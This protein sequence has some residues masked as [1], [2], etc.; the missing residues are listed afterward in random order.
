MHQNKIIILTAPS[1]AGKTSITHYLLRE[2]PQLAFSISVATRK[3]REN[4]VEGKDYYFMTE[5]EF[6]NR[7]KNN[8][9]VEWEMVYEGKIYGTLKSELERIWKNNQVPV[10][11]IDVKGAIHVQEQYPGTLSIFIDPPSVDELRRRLSSRGTETEESLQTR[12]NKAS[13]EISFKHHF[14]KIILNDNLEKA[15]TQAK[16]AVQQFLES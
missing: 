10:L 1:G 12:I 16:E 3:R 6:H 8:E 14:S 4:E 13:Y 2:F 9:F 5:E 11:D 7:N 15:C